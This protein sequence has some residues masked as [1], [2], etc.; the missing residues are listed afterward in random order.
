MVDLKALGEKWAKRWDE[1]K[2]F[3]ADPIPGKPKIFVTFPFPYMNGPLHIGHGFTSTRVDVYARFKRMQGYNVLFPWAWHLTGEPIAGAAERVAR[4]DESQIRI[5]REMDGVPE[6]DLK[7]F[8]DPKYIARYYIKESR[9]MVKAIGHS[10]DWRREFTTTSLHEQFNKF[11]EWQYLTLKDK[12]YV[13]K[14]THPVVWCPHDQSP[15]GDHDRLRGEGASPVEFTLL[16]FPYDGAYLPAATLRP[17]TIFGVTN[18]WINPDAEY[19][20]VSVDGEEWIVSAAAVEKLKE[21]K[22]GLRIR[23]KLNGSELIGKTCEHPLSKEEVL[24]LPASFVNPNNASGVVMSVPAHAPYDYLAL[25][26]L[27]ENPALLEKHG[28]AQERVKGIKPISMIRIASFGEYPAVEICERMGIKDQ[29]DPKAD[30]ATEAVYKEEFYKGILKENTGEYAGSKV[31]EVKKRLVSDL[32]GKGAADRM[33]ELTEEVVCRCNTACVVKILKDQWFLNFSDE[34]WKAKVLEALR[35]TRI[36]P[37]DARTNFEYTIDWLQAKACARKTGLGTPLPWDADWKVETLSDSTVYM[38]FYTIAKH[39]NQRG[40]K[41]TSLTREVFDYIFYG[42]GDP[43]D[44][45][46]RNK[47]DAVSLREMRSEFEYWMP[48]D[49][50]NSAK[51][52]IPNHLTFFLFHHVALFPKK[53]PGS[54]A[55]NGMI[56]IEGEK[57][58]KSKGNF[59]ALK[60]AISD[61]GADATR[62]ALLYSA[63]G[64]K[65]PD[66]RA[67]T[68]EDVVGKL[69]AFRELVSKFKGAADLKGM[70]SIDAWLLSKFQGHSTSATKELEDM[71]TR[72]ALQA[73]FFE[74]WVDVKWYLRRAELNGAAMRKALSIWVRLVAPYAPSLCEDLWSELGNKGFVSLAPWP[75]ADKALVDKA[76]EIAEELI[77]ETTRDIESILQVTGIKPKRILIYV[78]PKWKV[79][80]LNLANEFK[81]EGIKRIMEE[82]MKRPEIRKEG[83]A[84]AKYINDLMKDPSR[85]RPAG[86]IDEFAS[87]K[88]AA[89]FLGK[90]FAAK[91]EVC[92]AEDA[93]AYDPLKK[94]GNAAPL[95]PAIYID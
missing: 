16:K 63:E 74:P 89:D 11:I 55:V 87:L 79:G 27:Q 94:R 65:D 78:A 40:I 83:K 25:R 70:R 43:K 80:V 23:G 95:K 31:A 76:A 35:G 15:T 36:L 34:E 28:I 49:M 62:V 93:A 67:K 53:L 8:T 30:E 66:W 82:A 9:E 72:S 17:E 59:I 12:G 73:A 51:E 64:L 5:F 41:G 58:S 56:N 1:S 37:E 84:A 20:R 69:K 38:A 2:I 71:N 57:M 90:E 86:E 77:M 52:L 26:D 81:G 19:A 42:V 68:A 60:K 4:G 61:Y 91:V 7:H 33:Y 88:E 29:K 48:V 39:I 54:I 44:L 45:G 21:Q 3:E 92:S 10:V 22:D 6:A 50:R 75:E 18:M 24:I 85:I 13:V 32:Q 14:G 47:I 46:S